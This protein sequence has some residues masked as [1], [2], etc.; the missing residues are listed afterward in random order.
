MR[1]EAK[2]EAKE[3]AREEARD[4]QRELEIHYNDYTPSKDSTMLRPKYLIFIEAN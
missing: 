4:A 3:E 2:E 1:G